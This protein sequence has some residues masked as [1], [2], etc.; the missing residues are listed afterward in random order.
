LASP[1]PGSRL[2]RVARARITIIATTATIRITTIA[3]VTMT[4]TKIIAILTTTATIIARAG[5]TTTIIEMSA[6]VDR[7]ADWR[8]AHVARAQRM[9]WIAADITNTTSVGS[10]ESEES[11]R[12]LVADPAPR[13]YRG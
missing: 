11:A 6:N 10:P 7:N 5:I 13:A 3:I 4:M 8:F 9:R 2:Q 1:L 12:D